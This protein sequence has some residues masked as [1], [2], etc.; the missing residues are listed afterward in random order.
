MGY[1]LAAYAVT[2]GAVGLYWIRLV[3]ES[4]RLRAELGESGDR[5]AP[6]RFRG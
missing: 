1:L 6:Q 5:E 3:R 2:V 4:R